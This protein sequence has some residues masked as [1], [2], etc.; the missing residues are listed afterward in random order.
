MAASVARWR[1][2]AQESFVLARRNTYTGGTIITRG[3]LTVN[4]QGGSGTG[5]GPVPGQR[6][7]PR[8]RS[9]R[10]L[11]AGQCRQWSCRRSCS[12]AGHGGNRSQSYYQ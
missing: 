1:R 8:R 6:R 2:P 5:I 7:F 10:L 4:N 11:G 3:H 12:V 9:G